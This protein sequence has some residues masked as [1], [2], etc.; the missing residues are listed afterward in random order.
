[1]SVNRIPKLL[2]QHK[3]R[4]PHHGKDQLESLWN[5]LNRPTAYLMIL[6]MVMNLNCGLMGCD[7]AVLWMVTNVVE[8]LLSHLPDRS[9]LP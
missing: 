9:V 6:V 4:S 8:D 3:N 5:K 1:M 2:C 7:T